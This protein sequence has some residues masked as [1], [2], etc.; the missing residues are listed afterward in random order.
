[1]ILISKATSNTITL[2][3][4]E[5]CDLVLPKFLFSFFNVEL[6]QTIN[7]ILTD[8]SLFTERYNRFTLI[9]GTTATFGVGYW[10]Y[11]VYE[12]A[13]ASNTDPDLASQ[14]VEEGK[15]KV[16]EAT[17]TSQTIYEINSPNNTVYI[18]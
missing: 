11:K 14:L 15:M 6:K 8:T 18:P 7:I 2:T 1:M 13:S 5:K 4:S 10:E 17:T 3:L 16:I 12:Q 9:E